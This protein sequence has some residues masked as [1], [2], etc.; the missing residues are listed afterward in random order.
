MTVGFSELSSEGRLAALIMASLSAAA[1][2]RSQRPTLHPQKTFK[3]PH[4]EEFVNA[5]TFGA[6]DDSCHATRARKSSFI[7]PGGLP[8]T[9][10]VTGDAVT[11]LHTVVSD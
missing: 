6:V 3:R 1:L 9:T 5:R 4:R 7:V 10:R 11:V 8:I 2:Q